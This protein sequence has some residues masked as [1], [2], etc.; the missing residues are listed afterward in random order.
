M[1]NK[2]LKLLLSLLIISFS[3]NSY[4]VQYT[5]KLKNW[6][7][8]KVVDIKRHNNKE[9]VY[10]L[11]NKI[12]KVAY[13]KVECMKVISKTDEKFKKVLIIKENNKIVYKIGHII[14]QDRNKITIQ[15][16]ETKGLEKIKVG[17]V[18]DIVNEEDFIKEEKKSN[19]RA[20][21]LSFLYPGLGQFYTYGKIRSG[22][23][24]STSF[25]LMWA[26]GTFCFFLTKNYWKEYEKS[27]F[28]EENYYNKY[29]VHYYLTAVSFGISG[30][31]YI[32]NV[33]DAYFR[34]KTKYNLNNDNNK[35][36]VNKFSFNMTF[37][38]D[39]NNSLITKLSINYHF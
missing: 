23:L 17:Q 7:S 29:R 5:L 39:L 36:S 3:I 13:K 12:Y 31:I 22:I 33:L 8:P 14:Y 28:A 27:K 10:K 37:I 38:P 21:V 19:N 25:T 35:L 6:K 32:W 16:S 30:I 2:L 20:L 26:T 9:F 1:E 24:F 15:I 18:L 34:F 11:N 4:A